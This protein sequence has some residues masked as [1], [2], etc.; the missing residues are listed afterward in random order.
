M[1]HVISIFLKKIRALEAMVNNNGMN[2]ANPC[3]VRII[4]KAGLIWWE[5]YA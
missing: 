3:D 5:V 2:F 1:H 4:S